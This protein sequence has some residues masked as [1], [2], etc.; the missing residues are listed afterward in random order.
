MQF[1]QDHLTYK[2]LCVLDQAIDDCHAAPLHATLGLRFTLAYLYAVSDGRREPY[3]AFWREVRDAKTI[4]YSDSDQGY[5]RATYAR[6]QL[7]RI[8]RGVGIELTADIM[9][10]PRD[11]RKVRSKPTVDL[12]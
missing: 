2:A 1:G 4:A 5:L 9:Q 12:Y 11:A 7:C 3:D 10:R 8:S 6:T